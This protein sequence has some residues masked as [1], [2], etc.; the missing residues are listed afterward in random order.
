[1]KILASYNIKG[2]VGKTAAAINLAYYAA[3]SGARTLIWDLDP[4][5]A[6]TFYLRVKAKV[7]G[8]SEALLKQKRELDSVIKA[9]NYPNLDILPADFSYRNMDLV[10]DDVKKHSKRLLKILRPLNQEYDYVILDCPPSISLVSENVFRAADAL[11]VP[12]IPTPLSLHTLEQLIGFCSNTKLEHLQI[13]PFLSM[14][15]RRKSL[16]RN[17]MDQPPPIL[18]NMLE[19]AIP[20]ATEVEQMGEHRAPI[21]EFARYSKASIAFLNLWYEIQRKV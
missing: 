18:H 10:L 11:L 8:G 21:G 9:S 13:L 3:F 7:K 17:I 6:A 19:T 1:M 14:V 16:H 5:G 15:D 12:T 20:Y 2:G 4:Q